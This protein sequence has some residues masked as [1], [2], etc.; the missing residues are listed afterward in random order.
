MAN[1]CIETRSIEEIAADTIRLG[2]ELQAAAQ[3]VSLGRNSFDAGFVTRSL[4]RLG[5]RIA[6]DPRDEGSLSSVRAILVADLEREQ[7]GSELQLVDTY[8]IDGDDS[9]V[10]REVPTYSQ[11]GR[12]LLQVQLLLDR[13]ATARDETLDRIAAERALRTLLTP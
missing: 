11:R 10:F 2:R 8:C 7:L 12:A 1:T 13:F 4:K 9:E 5:E 3:A 6:F